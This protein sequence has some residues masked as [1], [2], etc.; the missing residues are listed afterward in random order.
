MLL[1]PVCVHHFRSS[2]Y[3]AASIRGFSFG[4]L[5]LRELCVIDKPDTW[6]LAEEALTPWEF[7]GAS[8]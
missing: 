6:C 7:N 5:E 4:M 2:D 1:L 3:E 8:S